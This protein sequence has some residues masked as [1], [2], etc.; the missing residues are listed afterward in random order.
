MASV[1]ID[2][3][4]LARS[5]S[6]IKLANKLATQ[7]ERIRFRLPFTV[8]GVHVTLRA[9]GTS[10]SIKHMQNEP[11]TGASDGQQAA[12][13]KASNLG[14]FATNPALRFLLGILPSIPVRVK[15]LTILHK[16]QVHRPAQIWSNQGSPAA[17]MPTPQSHLFIMRSIPAASFTPPGKAFEPG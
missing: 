4:S 11:N 1:T 10:D 13:S 6:P 9:A 3:I 2:E 8:R 14:A 16:V 17:V 5:K 7:H 15:Q 12:R